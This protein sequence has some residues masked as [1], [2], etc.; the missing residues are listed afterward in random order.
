MIDP[1][2]S[3]SSPAVSEGRESPANFPGKLVTLHPEDLPP[4]ERK[5]FKREPFNEQALMKGLI[6]ADDFDKLDIPERTP[7]CGGW[8]LE[9]DMGFI[10]A[11]RGIGKTWSAM[12]LARS[13]SEGRPFGPWKITKPHTVLYVDGEMALD[14]LRERDCSLKK[15]SSSLHF[16]NHERLFDQT[17]F[18]LN[19]TDAE[20]QY[21]LR[22]LCEMKGVQVLIL[23]NL[24][25]LFRNMAE[26]DADAWEQV[27]PWLLSLRRRNIAVVIVHHANRTGQNMRGTFRR[28]DAA[29]WVIQLRKVTDPLR[30]HDG[31]H[32]VSRFTKH[33]H[34]RGSELEEVDWYYE[35]KDGETQLVWR[36]VASIDTF[37][38]LVGDGMTSCSDI[39]DAMELS[40]AAVC[41]IAK[42]AEALG[43]LMIKNRN[44]HLA[45]ADRE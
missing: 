25:C 3:H 12:D 41:K 20:V 45:D 18:V 4:E 2:L 44:Y 17:G 43:W 32:F 40:R 8:F 21:R 16:L 27:L 22:L 34:G 30:E 7:I 33:R 9:S 28:E 1:E 37:K 11:E 31:A 35:R 39:A 38:R 36:S 6:A 23:D 13:V 19:L 15:G 5:T 14:S 10:F 24:S 26:N 42:R 29:S